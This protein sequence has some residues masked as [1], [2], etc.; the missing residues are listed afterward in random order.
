MRLMFLIS[1]LTLLLSLGGIIFVSTIN[2]NHHFSEQEMT[3]VITDCPFMEHGETIC[4]MTAFDHILILKSIFETTIPNIV[5]LITISGVLISFLIFPKLK[6]FLYLHSHTFLR[7]R[8]SV[9]YLFSYRPLQ[10]LFS[11][12]L[13][14]P[15]LF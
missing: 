6:P 12:G 11:R 10:D 9:I 1:T 7:W 14:N 2:F 13:L 4:P 8:Q 15:K 5:T 3:S